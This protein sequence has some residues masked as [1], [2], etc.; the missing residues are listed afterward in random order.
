MI[1][2]ISI[3]KST[4]DTTRFSAMIFYLWIKLNETAQFQWK[5]AA[6]LDTSNQN[7]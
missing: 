2:E 3:L 6:Y 1:E 7:N 4:N 5:L